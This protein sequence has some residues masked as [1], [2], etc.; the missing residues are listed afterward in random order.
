MAKTIDTDIAVSLIDSDAKTNMRLLN[1]LISTV[2]VSYEHGTLVLTSGVVDQEIAN[3]G[4]KKLI[5]ISSEPITIKIGDTTATPMTNV[6]SF[7][8]DS[9]DSNNLF[10]SNPSG[11]DSIITFV[12]AS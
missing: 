11:S 1:R 4:F 8:L 9:A 2:M 3:T 7:I 6:T 5:I 12:F 10:L